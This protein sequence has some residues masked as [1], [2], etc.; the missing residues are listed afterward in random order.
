MALLNNIQMIYGNGWKQMTELIK[1]NRLIYKM[2]NIDPI[3]KL[4]NQ[5]IMPLQW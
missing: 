1:D 3:A 2:F 5:P 4:G